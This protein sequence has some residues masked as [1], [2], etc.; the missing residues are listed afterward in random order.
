MMRGV[1]SLT[2]AASGGGAQA[3]SSADGASGCVWL[4]LG[5]KMGSFG[6]FWFAE[7]ARG[8]G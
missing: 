3:A 8:G 5:E 1:S 6:I 2:I 4:G 7:A